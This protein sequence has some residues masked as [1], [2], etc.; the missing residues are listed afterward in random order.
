M[1][2]ERVVQTACV[3][4]CPGFC[5]LKAHVRDGT[6]V[7]FSSE[8]SGPD[9]IYR[10]QLRACARGRAYRQRVYHPDR[11]LHPLIRTGERGSGQFRQASWD[12]ALDTAAASI[13]R[14]RER[15]GND[16]IFVLPGSG[17]QGLLRGNVLARRLMAL[18]GGFL[19]YY[20]NYSTNCTTPATLATYGAAE[21]GNSFSDLV[22]SRLIILWAANWAWT[23]AG[24]GAPFYLKQAREAGARL[25]YVDP[26]YT[27][28]AV[29]FADE[30]IPIIPGTD[31][32]MMDAMA[33]VMIEENLHDQAF[34][35][36]YCVGFDE[37]HLP[38]GAPPGSSYRSYVLGEADGVPKTPTWA[39]RITGVPAERIVKL[40]REY[41]TIKPAAL[42]LGWGP[43]RT[44]YGEQ[45]ARGGMVLASMT[46]NVGIS[47][48][49]A[50]G[51]G[52]CS[53]QVRLASPAIPNPLKVSI[54]VFLW[55]EAIYRAPEM[56]PTEGVR[57]AEKLRSNL[58]LLFNFQGNILLN[59]H[60]NTNRT[61]RLLRDPEKVEFILAA[62]Q[63]L[64]PSARFADVVF[65]AVTW[66]EREDVATGGNWSEHALFLNQ[67][68]E[69]LG[70]ARTDYWALSRLA[71][72]LGIGPE[73]T[74][75]RDEQAWLR[76][77]LAQSGIDY[78]AFKREG[79][80]QPEE[81]TPYVAFADFRRDPEKHPLQ[82][83]S[84]KIEI[85]SQVA[86]SLGNPKEIP[87]VPKYIESWE[88]R[89]DPLW[90]KYPL[91]LLTPHPRYRTHTIYGNLPWIA[92]I[93]TEAVFINP[94]DAEPRGI[95]S[96]DLVRAWNDRGAVLLPAQVT[97]RIMPGVV[98]IQQGRWYTPREDGVDVG[99]CANTLTSHR[100]TPWAKGNPQGTNL[101][102]IAREEM[103]VAEEVAATNGE[104][105]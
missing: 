18:Y 6:I 28:T 73:F 20:G 92:E 31:N 36:R 52:G 101:V 72:R 57:G 76:H 91:Q 12:E 95:R 27:D 78:D 75:G 5:I 29:A 3:H 44:A 48:G 82:T 62:D 2:E 30:W 45:P 85:Y 9:T 37:A 60:S 102:Q 26:Q 64:T 103:A 21:S 40:A 90:E 96:G 71:E 14:I 23:F 42:L 35:D 47:G 33:Y 74:E 86:A 65:P 32:A 98:A 77:L 49:S 4:D 66:V 58:K 56:G 70:E 7:R 39:E 94:A 83:P 17:H 100:P 54:P 61:A 53:R 80:Y 67:A 46:G 16:A 13:A 10:R 69:P 104:K 50:A 11:L 99:G 22:N 24:A 105:L 55:T 25:I 34:L 87:A 51:I 38:P 89:Y 63:F 59:Q 43:Q 97:E 41:A 68:I 15:Y 8:D 84:G 79:R 19:D 81:S 93:S 1:T 88:G